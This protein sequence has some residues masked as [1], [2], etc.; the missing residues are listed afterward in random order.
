MAS[1]ITK[2]IIREDPWQSL[3]SFTQARIA[4]GKT[5]VAVPLSEVLSFRLSHAH[6]RDA[7]FSGMKTDKL[8]EGFHQFNLPVHELQSLAGN[9]VVYLQRPDHGRKLDTGSIQILRQYQQ[10]AFDI[11]IIIADGLSGAAV[12]SHAVLLLEQVFALLQ[13][14]SFSIAPLIIVQQGRVA[15]ADE[16]GQLLNAKLSLILI[17]ERPGLT[18]SESLGAYIT[19]QPKSGLTD[20]SRNCISNIHSGGLSYETAARKIVYLIRFAIELKL[21]G[22]GLKEDERLFLNK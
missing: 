8:R 5:G 10:S 17:G 16:I 12:N 7:V 13:K 2:K 11:V 18:T 9:R 14:K 19:Y 1:E 20:E 22:I 3:K 21:S 15:I 4:L 6:A